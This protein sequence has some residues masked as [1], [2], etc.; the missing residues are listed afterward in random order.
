MIK[1]THDAKSMG[2]AG[3]SAG[4]T[5]ARRFATEHGIAVI[6]KSDRSIIAYDRFGSKFKFKP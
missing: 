4:Q 5:L 6:L 1:W 2:I 3:K